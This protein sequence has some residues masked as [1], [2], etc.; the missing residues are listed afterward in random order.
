M[1]VRSLY[2]ATMKATT[3]VIFAVIVVAWMFRYENY[4][5]VNSENIWHRNRFTAAI[6]PIDQD[7]F[8]Y[9]FPNNLMP[10]HCIGLLTKACRW[11][12]GTAADRA[13]L[14]REHYWDK[15]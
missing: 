7:C 3:V 6:C 5:D 8:L 10:W 4:K 9:T 13:K 2:E 11:D 1:E 12:W 15:R 14:E